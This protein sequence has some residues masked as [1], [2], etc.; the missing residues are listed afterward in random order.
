[1][2]DVQARPE[3][4]KS[5]KRDV[6]ARYALLPLEGFPASRLPTCAGCSG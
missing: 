2:T 1:M 6:E 5:R 3:T 4:V